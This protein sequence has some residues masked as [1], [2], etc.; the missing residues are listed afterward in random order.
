MN[1]EAERQITDLVDRALAHN[2]EHGEPD[3]TRI[4]SITEAYARLLR[5]EGEGARAFAKACEDLK[6]AREADV[7]AY[8]DSAL[9]GNEPPKRKEVR[10]KHT[11]ENLELAEDGYVLAF[12]LIAAEAVEAVQE[13][14]RQ[15]DAHELRM[16]R[17]RLLPFTERPESLIDFVSAAFDA[18]DRQHD[19]D[20]HARYMKRGY[21]IAIK[22]VQQAKV[23]HTRLGLDMLN[24][25]M[26]RYPEIVTQED[27]SF[28]STM[29]GKGAIQ[30]QTKG[31]EIFWPGSIQ[32]LAE[33]SEPQA[34]PA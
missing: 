15:L 16:L 33:N 21:D 25:Q 6:T 18:S 7:R 14:R 20:E 26:S 27:L 2:D 5:N 23:E 8:A 12:D 22:H 19:A 17:G 28:L 4:D 3:M 34:T 1:A 24:F 30:N 32:D 9:A 29:P 13:G 31:N 10:L 11:I